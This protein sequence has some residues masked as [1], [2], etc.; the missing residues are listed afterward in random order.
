MTY[1]K[2]AQRDRNEFVAVCSVF[3]TMIA[4]SAGTLAAEH[5]TLWIVLVTILAGLAIIVI[6]EL[7][8]ISRPIQMLKR[9]EAQVAEL[10]DFTQQWI[11]HQSSDSFITIMINPNDALKKGAST[12]E[13]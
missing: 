13:S 6:T 12:P 11:T 1:L 2:R 7:V 10:R 9:K 4:I 3:G 5:N 8:K